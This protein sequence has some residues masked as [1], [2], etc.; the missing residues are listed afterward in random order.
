MEEI[1]KSCAAT[2]ATLHLI[3]FQKL[4]FGEVTMVDIFSSA[5]VAIIDLSVPE[6]QWSLLYYLGIRENFDMRQN[7]LLFNENSKDAALQL[8][9][10][11]GSYDL[12]TYRA[13]DGKCVVTESRTGGSCEDDL[14][15]MKPLSNRL[16][17]ILQDFVVQQK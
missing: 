4:D 5:D 2:S 3:S 7:V 9:L 13:I 11:C 1:H 12:I 16:V 17:K 10:S 14:A 8:R 6:Q 15:E